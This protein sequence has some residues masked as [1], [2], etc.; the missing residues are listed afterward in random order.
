MATKFDGTIEIRLEDKEGNSKEVLLNQDMVLNNYQTTT[1]NAVAAVI[2]LTIEKSDIEPGDRIRTYA[3]SKGNS[4]WMLVGGRFGNRSQSKVEYASYEI[5]VKEDTGTG[6]EEVEPNE[7]SFY[8]ETDANRN[9]TVIDMEEFDQ[10]SVYSTTGVL[11]K[12]FDVGSQQQITFSCSDC[13]PGIYILSLQSKQGVKH[14][15]FML[16]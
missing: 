6:V 16:L 10:I 3:K 8:I 9:I 15:K 4:E 1:A 14:R 13:P 2:D 12:R 11:Q 5:I 7:S